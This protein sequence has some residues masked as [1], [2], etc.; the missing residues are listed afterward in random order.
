MAEWWAYQL[1]QQCGLIPAPTSGSICTTWY[2]ASLISCI[3][4]QSWHRLDGLTIAIGVKGLEHPLIRSYIHSLINEI[5]IHNILLII[6]A[7]I[8]ENSETPPA[9]YA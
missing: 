1:A 4:E 9:S 8:Y 3:C 6:C 5:I 7:S 2:L